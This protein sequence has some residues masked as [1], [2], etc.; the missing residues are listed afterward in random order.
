MGNL[1]R[2]NLHLTGTYLLHSLLKYEVEVHWTYIT[3]G[4]TV[5]WLHR[6]DGHEFE[7]APGVGDGLGSLASMGSQ[8]VRTTG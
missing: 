4:E 5:G 1:I 7:Q 6:L 8:R 3:E 2:N